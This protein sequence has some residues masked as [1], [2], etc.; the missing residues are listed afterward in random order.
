MKRHNEQVGKNIY[1]LSR[2]IDCVKFCGTFELAFH[3]DDENDQSDSLSW[4]GKF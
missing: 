4:I 3:G 1:V 2:I